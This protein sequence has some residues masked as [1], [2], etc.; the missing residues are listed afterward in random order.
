MT[1][2]IVERRRK[3]SEKLNLSKFGLSEARVIGSDGDGLRFK[4]TES[5]KLKQENKE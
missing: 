3:L 2:N 4:I 1:E 5:K